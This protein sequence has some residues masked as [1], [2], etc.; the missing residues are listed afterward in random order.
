MLSSVDIHVVFSYSQHPLTQ[1]LLRDRKMCSKQRRSELLISTSTVKTDVLQEHNYWQR[2]RS[3]SL[4]KYSFRVCRCFRQFFVIKILGLR[5]NSAVQN[6]LLRPLDQE[7]N[8]LFT[9]KDT[10]IISYSNYRT[11]SVVMMSFIKYYR[12]YFRSIEEGGGGEGNYCK[13]RESSCFFNLQCFYFQ[14]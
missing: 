4:Q 12:N 5:T 13:L 2:R 9:F 11:L 1:T 3:S 8:Y 14:D 10:Q 6:S 7:K